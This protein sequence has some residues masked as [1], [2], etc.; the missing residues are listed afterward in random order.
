MSTKDLEIQFNAAEFLK[1]KE[2]TALSD[3]C[4]LDS[5]AVF[6]ETM[7]ILKEFDLDMRYLLYVM[8]DNCNVMQ[9]RNSGYL[10]KM[11]EV[12]PNLLT[13]PG[14]SC[15]QANLAAKE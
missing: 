8:T 5:E 7:K 1:S 2:I 14:C 3:L 11:K 6:N 13:I 4:L 15:H 9:G 12:C 10:G